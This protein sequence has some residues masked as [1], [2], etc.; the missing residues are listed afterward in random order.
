[1]I[2]DIDRKI[3]KLIQSN[4]RISHSEIAREVGMAASAIFE[5]LRK[6]EKRGVI[7]GYETRLNPQAVDLGLVAFIFIR[8]HGPVGSLETEK[9]LAQIPEVLE[10]HDVAGEDCYLIKVRVAH[11]E[12]LSR[13]LREKIGPIQTI[14]STRTTIVLTTVKE[15]AQL[16]IDDES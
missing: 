15:T 12:A 1:M 14:S 11:T 5:R 10:I 13:L 6:L 9:R 16:P 3:L 7:Q 8:A 2:D 4:A